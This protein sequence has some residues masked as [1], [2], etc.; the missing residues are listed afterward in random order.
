M[1]RWL[2]ILLITLGVLAAA[3]VAGFVLWGLNPLPPM[4]EANAALNSDSQ[5]T[6]ETG[7][8]LVFQPVGGQAETGLIF[9]PGGHVDPRAYAP[10]AHAIAG[11][12]YLV[13]IVPMPLNL[14]VFNPGA[15]AEVIAAY[16]QVRRWAVSGHSLGGS[17]A[18]NFVKKHPGAVQALVLWASYPGSS[19]DL[20]QAG[21]RTASIYATLDGLT[22]GEDIAASHA[23][24]PAD[25]T[26][27]A[28]QGG[29][30]AQFGWYGDQPGDN[31]AAISRPDQQ[32]QVIQATLE[33]LANLP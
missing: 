33:L 10:P 13:V 27:T 14:A 16:P 1:K 9:Y 26:W 28:I 30:H 21:V 29:N 15:A 4:P 20:S 23:L 22:T 18:A 3:A 2:R 8:W 6:V 24:L 19:D 5:V 11:Q 12:G 17:M 31:P 32:A 25:T 7:R